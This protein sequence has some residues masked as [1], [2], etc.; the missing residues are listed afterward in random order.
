MAKSLASASLEERFMTR[1]YGGGA[2]Q[3]W[4][5]CPFSWKNDPDTL[6]LLKKLA[7]PNLVTAMSLRTVV[8]LARGWKNDLDTF[9]WLQELVRPNEAGIMHLVV[10][11]QHDDDLLTFVF[12]KKLA[13]KANHPIPRP[14]KGQKAADLAIN[15]KNDSLKLDCS[16]FEDTSAILT[17]AMPFISENARLLPLEEIPL[18][19]GNGVL[20]FIGG[21]SVTPS[22]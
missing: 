2:A 10:H 19:K 22:C 21:R 16:A 3:G 4:R 11:V 18:T 20:P 14:A 7:G 6:P 13:L 9:E 15:A 12:F 1:E 8:E 5:D 17:V